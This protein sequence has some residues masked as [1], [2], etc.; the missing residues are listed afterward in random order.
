MDILACVRHPHALAIVLIAVACSPSASLPTAA[1]SPPSVTTAS[2]GSASPA[3]TTSFASEVP[4]TA[5]AV[6]TPASAAIPARTVVCRIV[7]TSLCERARRTVLDNNGVKADYLVLD[8]PPGT[9]LTTP[10]A[11]DLDKAKESGNLSGF[12]GIVRG[13]PA[14]IVRGDIAFANMLRVPVSAG[15]QIAQVGSA[16]TRI[17]LDERFNVA[18]T[19]TRRSDS[20]P[21]VDLDALRELFPLAFELPPVS[22]RQGP[23]GSPTVIVDHGPTPPGAPATTRP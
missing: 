14:L 7:P 20:G 3:S 9:P 4:S 18:L 10:V 8:L 21:V 12:F 16:G 23:P 1:A 17:G 11:G 15:A 19:M 5:A 2:S 6:A 22:V 13:V